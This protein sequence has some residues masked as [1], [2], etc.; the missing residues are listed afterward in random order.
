[1]YFYGG[2]R[3]TQNVAESSG[4]RRNRSEL[5]QGFSSGQE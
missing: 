4:E 2:G 3:H 1:M 5:L